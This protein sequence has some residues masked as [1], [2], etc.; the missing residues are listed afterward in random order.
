MDLHRYKTQNKQDGKRGKNDQAKTDKAQTHELNNGTEENENIHNIITDTMKAIV[1]G[2]TIQ[3]A[4]G[5]MQDPS[6]TKS[7]NIKNK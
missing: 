6:T 7:P 4:A 2:P 1:S 5:T 3:N